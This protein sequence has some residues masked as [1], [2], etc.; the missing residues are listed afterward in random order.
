MHCAAAV[1][2]PRLTRRIISPRSQPHSSVSRHGPTPGRKPSNR[3]YH[4][5]AYTALLCNRGRFFTVSP[6]CN[7]AIFIVKNRRNRDFL[8][9][10]DSEAYFSLP[11]RRGRK[12][13]LT[14]R[15]KCVCVCVCVGGGGGTSIGT[16]S[17]PTRRKWEWEWGGGEGGAGAT[18]A[19]SE[20]QAKAASHTSKKNKK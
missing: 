12:G 16:P 9:N 1:S 18:T 11:S 4:R 2:L 17:T 7:S 6:L 13:E 8:C 15:A 19:Q 20:P 5:K 10:Y 14:Q 3:D